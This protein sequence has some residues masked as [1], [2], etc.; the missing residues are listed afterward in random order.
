MDG[1]SRPRS[2]SVAWCGVTG[3]RRVR[4]EGGTKSP[5][6]AADGRTSCTSDSGSAHGAP[7]LL[8]DASQGWV[9]HGR[10]HVCTGSD[11]LGMA[12][13]MGIGSA[14]VAGRGCFRLAPTTGPRVTA[15]RVRSDLIFHFEDKKELISLLRGYASAQSGSATRPTRDCDGQPL[16]TMRPR[17]GLPH[18][19][20]ACMHAYVR[21]DSRRSPEMGGA[22]AP[23]TARGLAPPWQAR[24]A[25]SC[26]PGHRVCRGSNTCLTASA[27]M[28]RA[29]G[30]HT[31]HSHVGVVE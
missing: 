31:P 8:R 4:C 15:C 28:P 16:T 26:T 6:S 2:Q 10:M 1:R 21:A 11:C 29:P 23:T 17:G 19:L 25:Y 18:T 14:P 24:G 20:E 13:E 30:L 22:F 9:E 12:S 27:G 7:R 3:T 5:H